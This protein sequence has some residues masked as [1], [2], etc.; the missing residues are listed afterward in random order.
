M[1][2]LTPMSSQMQMDPGL[3]LLASIYGLSL[4]LLSARPL[5]GTKLFKNEKD[6]TEAPRD[7]CHGRW[8]RPPT[9]RL[10]LGAMPRPE[11]PGLGKSQPE[12]K[13]ERPDEPCSLQTRQVLKPEDGQYCLQARPERR[14]LPSAPACLG[15]L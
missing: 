8:R 4:F 9:A 13:W 15:L 7:D 2:T 1:L 3:S 6:S 5:A 12:M 11:S 10:F 14:Q